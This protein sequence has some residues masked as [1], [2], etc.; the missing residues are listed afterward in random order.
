MRSFQRYLILAFYD[1]K[2]VYKLFAYVYLSFYLL[3]RRAF[4]YVRSIISLARCIAMVMVWSDLV[5]DDREYTSALVAMNSIFQ[6]LFF[7]TLTYIY[8]D[9]SKIT[10]SKHFRDIDF[11]VLSKN[12]LI[13]LG[14]PFLMG[15]I[16]RTLLLKYKSK[17]WYENTFLPKI[18]PVTLITLL[19]TII[20]MCSYKA[21]EVFRLPLEACFDFVFYHHVFSNLVYF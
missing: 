19:V 11:S 5:K 17:Q 2:L 1:F 12:V 20:I 14:I 8:L 3:K 18:S 10:R 7:S 16:T 21:N 9:F 4:I 15:F 6:I 13:Y